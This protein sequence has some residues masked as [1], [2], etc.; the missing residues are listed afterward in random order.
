MNQFYFDHQYN[1]TGI[2]SKYQ[3]PY[4]PLRFRR[5]FNSKLTTLKIPQN[6]ILEFKSNRS[7]DYSCPF[8]PT[9]DNYIKK[10]KETKNVTKLILLKRNNF[11][12]VQLNETQN[13]ENMEIV[14]NSF[15]NFTFDS[16]FNQKKETFTFQNFKG[17]SKILNSFAYSEETVNQ[18][19]K[20]KRDL[21][22]ETP[23]IEDTF[24]QLNK[25]LRSL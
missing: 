11:Q 15:N 5:N 7:E 18:K 21:E 23:D 19:K 16:S 12:T 13:E 2:T 1:D 4:I 25:K 3:K 14:P 9:T 17:S 22:I 6:I 20:R 24:L 8:T 10:I